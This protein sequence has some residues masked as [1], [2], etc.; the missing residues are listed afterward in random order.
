MKSNVLIIFILTCVSLEL[1]AQVL[2][3]PPTITS[4]PT[5]P[6]SYCFGATPIISFSASGIGNSYRW[7]ITGPIGCEFCSTALNNNLTYAGVTSTTLLIRT[8]TLTPGTYRYYCDVTNAGGYTYTNTV[9]FTILSTVLPPTPTTTS[10]ARCGNG[11]LTL[12]ASGGT[13]GQ[14]RWYTVASGGTAIAG[15]T[16]NIFTT[17]SLTVT[18]N[19]YVALNN[20]TCEGPRTIVTAT[21]NP[22]PAAPTTT[23]ASNCGS[24][25]VTLNAAGGTA[26]Q[27][28]WYTVATGGTALAGQTNATYTTPVLTGTT[29][30][31]VAINNGLCEGARSIV[32]ATI[33]PI[34][35][36]PTTTGA[37]ICGSGS[38]TLNAS[39][40]VAG[41][42]R[43]Y[44]VAT[45]GT[46]IAGQTAA[47]YITPALTG[48]INYY[49]AIN[50]GTCE[51]NRT[52][53][54]A[55]INPLPTPPTT[56]GASSCG[57]GSVTLNASGGVA[58]QYRWYTVAAG[59]TAIAGQTNTAYTT[60]TLTGT[61][62]YY[63]TINNGTCESNRTIV[64]ATINPPPTAPSTTGAN[65]CGSG[66]VTLNAS[67]GVAGQYR[68]YTVATGG[69]ALAGQTVATYTTPTLTGT[70]NYYVAINNGTCESNRTLVTAT[71]NP[72]PTAPSTTGAS[73]CGSGSVTLNA[74]GGTA[75]QY[76]WYTVATGGTA[77]AGQTNAAYTT[78]TLTGTTNY[79]VAIN[80]GTCESN[81][82]IVTAT[83]NPIPT[84]PTTTGASI[85]GSGSVTLNASGG[86]AGQYRWYTVATG[87]TAIAGQTNAA[88]TTPTLTGTSNYSVAI[89]N[90]T[91][92][93]NRTIVTATINPIPAAPSTTGAS[94][95]GS[96]S[97]TLNASGGVAGQYRWYTVSTGGTAITGQT[98]AAYTT[99]TL[100][101][102]TNY[103][104]AINN[105]TCESN[106]TIVTATINPVPTP[107]TTTGASS[108]GSGSV[109]L[110]ASGGTAG[111][112]RWYT[113]A[114]GGTAIA[115]QTNAA[116][117][118]PTL[119]GTTNYYVAI[120]NG[121]CES[122]RTLVTAT[123]NPIPTAP[124]TTGNSSCVSAALLLTATGGSNGQYRWYTS[125][126]GGIAISGQTN[127]NYITPVISTSTY[128]YV[129]INN[130][131]CEG[132]RSPVFA[133]INPTPIAPTTSGASRCGPGS[134]ILNA[135]GAMDGQYLWY[136]TSTGGTPLGGQT[137]S[138]F[139]SPSLEAT[140][141]YFVSINF[142]VCESSRTSVTATINPIP[143]PPIVSDVVFCGNASIT[144]NA[145]GAQAGQYKWY[146]SSKNQIT[147][148]T[149]N[150]LTT[151][152][153]NSST[154]YYA[155]IFN[156]LCESS[157]VAIQVTIDKGKCNLPPAISSN[158]ESIEPGGT[159]TI[160]LF[161]LISDP[162]DNIDPTSL[163]IV[164]APSSGANAFIENGFL[165]VEYKGLVFAGRDYIIIEVCDSE[166]IC[167]QQEITID[168]EGDVNVYNGISPNRDIYNEKWIIQNI[169]SLQDTQKNK[170]SLFNR[171]GNMVFEM[172]DYDNQNRVFTGLSNDGGA[173]PSGVYFYKIEFSSG[174]P[175]L[176][177]YLTIKK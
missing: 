60:P 84:P 6:V 26:G 5:S 33:N 19:Y 124:V 134:V 116:Y 115:G 110:N 132:P 25:A 119:T 90:G 76:R 109:T 173:I 118:T 97:V 58:G 95:C 39:G 11:F 139:T 168:V 49:V 77:I 126:T 137:S 148:E 29:N 74:S 36:A 171:W 44:T 68:W 103:Y 42:Y 10:A 150:S 27:Y 131:I 113:V 159:V 89:N 107:P 64:T 59:G 81:R 80:N 16:N 38:V 66:T 152:I 167:V 114:T 9:D 174:K 32:T 100:T 121:T 146:D 83:I 143:S 55:T 4:Q 141:E 160:N 162:D 14:Y 21:I 105:G 149:S 34:P 94:I 177:G 135:S 12:S 142:G 43:W 37:S 53:V 96:G 54:T 104:V 91:C 106:R 52:I 102:T 163:K 92:E 79:Y 98:N 157:L 13:A 145:T 87:G 56:T 30:Y 28:R 2:P 136:T 129:A 176:T 165:I 161:D 67:G 140:T 170:V 62:N 147:G 85:C 48:T 154:T 65:N 108:C 138:T 125:A 24:G 75:G 69:T 111:Q 41:Q 101:G 169:E 164:T 156:N 46:A 112:Y 15:Q 120:N 122:N 128:Y 20:G 93:S 40:G 3:P 99:P 70:T 158:T 8:A 17:P 133:E 72:L 86:T 78:P 155:S 57:S 82:T 35:A 18:T 166:G 23:G 151:A 45:G 22:I 61:T 144:L 63:V 130:G 71:I 153:L 123:I 73:S 47:T 1:A 31:Y 175:V 117:T 172:E 127:A 7:Y 88:Y 50:N 51:S